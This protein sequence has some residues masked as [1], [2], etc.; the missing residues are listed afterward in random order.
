MTPFENF[1]ERFKLLASKNKYL[2]VNTLSNIFTNIFGKMII[3][4]PQTEGIKYAGS[5]LKILPYI[6][7][8]LGNSKGIRNVLDGFSGTTRVS[9]AFAKLG[10]TFWLSVQYVV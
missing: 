3:K 7:D 2:V 4:S 1:K 10:L 6:V 8:I 5:K 9:Q